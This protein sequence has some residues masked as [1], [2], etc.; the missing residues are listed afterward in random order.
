MLFEATHRRRPDHLGTCGHTSLVA[1]QDT[2]CHLLVSHACRRLGIGV[3]G[4]N[5]LDAREPGATLLALGQINLHAVI[6]DRLHV[7]ALMLA[8]SLRRLDGR[9]SRLQRQPLGL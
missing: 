1:V 2:R 5:E 7:R 8:V 3:V 9:V 6:E 4:V